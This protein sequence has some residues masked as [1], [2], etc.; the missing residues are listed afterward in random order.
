MNL[1]QKDIVSFKE[2]LLDVYCKTSNKK[3]ELLFLRIAAISSDSLYRWMAYNKKKIEPNILD[4]EVLESLI[5]LGNIR[6]EFPTVPTEENEAPIPF[7]HQDVIKKVMGPDNV[8]RRTPYI[9]ALSELVNN[10]EVSEILEPF[11]DILDMYKRVVGAGRRPVRL[12]DILNDLRIILGL[13]NESISPKQKE[14]TQRT[15]K[16]EMVTPN[17]RL[18]KKQKLS[19]M[20]AYLLKRFSDEISGAADRMNLYG[21]SSAIK[22]GVLVDP[23]RLSQLLKSPMPST[24]SVKDAGVVAK[25]VS[26]YLDDNYKEKN[27]E[28]IKSESMIKSGALSNEQMMGYYNDLSKSKEEDVSKL[29]SEDYNPDDINED[30]SKPNVKMPS[31]S[32]QN[33]QWLN[34]RALQYIS[35]VL[36]LLYEESK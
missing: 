27:Y 1:S 23:V 20:F 28:D 12:E 10:P 21:I 4:K 13:Y 18:T 36:H 2:D 24:S 26:R 35:I 11:S 30:S 29:L 32:L 6:K 25:R 31:L 15:P 7:S 33:S 19:K 8:S 14:T 9:L 3:I 16:D 34:P 17:I 5:A 22:R